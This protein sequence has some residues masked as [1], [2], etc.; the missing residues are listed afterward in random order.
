MSGCR[1]NRQKFELPMEQKSIIRNEVTA[2]TRLGSMVIDH[3]IMTIIAVLF[4]IPGMIS[5]FAEAGRDPH[6]QSDFEFFNDKNMYVF[7]IGLALY[8]CKDCIHG[9]SIAKRILGLQVVDNSTGAEASPV[10]CV[11]RNLFCIIWPIEVIAVVVNPQ[12]RLGDMVAGTTVVMFDKAAPRPGLNSGQIAFSLIIAYGFMLLLMMPFRELQRSI[13]SNN[14]RY[15]ASSY[16]DAASKELIKLYTD[17]LGQYLQPDIRVYDQIEK[18]NRKYISIFF[19]LNENY[20]EDKEEMRELDSYVTE[21]LRSR[22][23]RGTYT[24]QLK[25][26]YK[27]QA[28]RSW[29]TST[30]D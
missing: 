7:L 18:D 13:S 15:V 26:L 28:Y 22:Y 23:P 29:R 1:K 19:T 11:V 8:F 21:L 14:V 27:Q 12:R 5:V 30:L 25:Y 17:S 3:F 4:F 16:N 10:K 20:L 2:G 6:A 9:R 24:G